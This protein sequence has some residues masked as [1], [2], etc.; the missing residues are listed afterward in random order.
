[1]CK[2]R[3]VSKSGQPASCESTGYLVGPGEVRLSV[4]KIEMGCGTRCVVGSLPSS[5]VP[6][7]ASSWRIEGQSMVGEG[8]SAFCCW[9]TPQHRG[10]SNH[11]GTEEPSLTHK[12]RLWVPQQKM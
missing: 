10:E 4:I 3:W 9:T 11:R 6:L 1:M 2:D 12:Q 5:F 8:S 7:C